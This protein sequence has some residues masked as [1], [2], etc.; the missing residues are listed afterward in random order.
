MVPVATPLWFLTQTLTQ[1]NQVGGTWARHVTLWSVVSVWGIRRCRAAVM[2]QVKVAGDA[3]RSHQDCAEL[4]SDMATVSSSAGES[5]NT[6]YVK[7]IL[8]IVLL[9]YMFIIISPPVMELL[10][11]PQQQRDLQ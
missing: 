1:V 2:A 3:V 10:R 11:Q 8:V 4:Y 6:L 9:Y 7:M 5:K